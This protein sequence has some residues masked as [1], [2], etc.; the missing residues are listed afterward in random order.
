MHVS[1]DIITY[2]NAA[3]KV[4]RSAK[5]QPTLYYMIAIWHTQNTI[6]I[7]ILTMCIVSLVAI[8]AITPNTII[9]VEITFGGA[10][11]TT[12]LVW[13]KCFSYSYRNMK[14]CFVIFMLFNLC[15]RAIK[16]I[17]MWLFFESI[18]VCH[19]RFC[20]ISFCKFFRNGFY[21][22]N[23]R[24]LGFCRKRRASLSFHKRLSVHIK[25]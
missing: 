6:I 9:I 17:H 23:K 2:T 10:F 16:E 1:C 3:N 20:D 4:N 21:V 22:Y 5:K 7:L 15:M 24:D 18:I 12:E 13:E 11:V 14:F 19:Y 8:I 25:S